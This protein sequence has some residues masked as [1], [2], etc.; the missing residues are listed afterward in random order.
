MLSRRLI[1]F[2]AVPLVVSLV[3]G[4]LMLEDF[5]AERFERRMQAEVEM[6]ARSLKIPVGHAVNVDREGA[7]ERALESTKQIGRV[8][9]A[10]VF[11]EDGKIVASSRDFNKD[12]DKNQLSQL[13]NESSSDHK[14]G[15]ERVGGRDV[16]SHFVTLTEL[17]GRPSGFLQVTRL[18]SDF[19]QFMAELRWQAARYLLAIFLTVLVI[20]SLGYYGAAGRALS[21]LHQSIRRVRD[22]DWKHRADSF[23]PKEIALIASSFNEMLDTIDAAERE[24]AEQRRQQ[25]ELEEQLRR[26]ER[27]AALGRLAGGVAHELGTPLSTIMGRASQALREV[28]LS[29]KVEHN[30]QV[31]HRETHR[32]ERIVRELLDFGRTGLGKRR[33]IS[34]DRLVNTA[35]K[36][37]SD[38]LS[39]AGTQVECQGPS[40]GLTIPVD[41]ARFE[42]ALTNLI[43]NASQA[44]RGGRIQIAWRPVA[45]EEV[46]IVIEDDGS[47][48]EPDDRQR[49]FEPFYTTKRAEEGTGLGLSIVHAIVAEHGGRI[50]ADASTELGGARMSLRLPAD[51]ER[52][53]RE[54][55]PESSSLVQWI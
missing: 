17:D 12:L 29:D 43:K 9:S 53:S 16:Y 2:I 51:S 19:Q 11:N 28:Q 55:S 52:A 44:S 27:L 34:V 42:R 32:M 3:A 40:D 45:D 14:G 47:G 5:L 20:V 6:V 35:L 7:I 38:D 23:G 31:I 49:I 30:L 26:S 1:L 15:Y 8:Y 39:E 33:D 46:E 41:P 21:A 50:V 54:E 10:D 48:I 22:G 18:K 36:A 24:L 13:A 37:V 4:G 25:S